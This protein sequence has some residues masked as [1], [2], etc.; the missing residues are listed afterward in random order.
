MHSLFAN[1][2]SFPH[3]VSLLFLSGGACVVKSKR[4]TLVLHVGCW[5]MRLTTSCQYIY[6]HSFI[7]IQP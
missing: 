7:S 3:K 6:I 5:G 1:A 2:Y 4:G